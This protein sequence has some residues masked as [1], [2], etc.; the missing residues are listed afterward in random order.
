MAEKFLYYLGAG[1]SANALPIVNDIKDEGGNT[2]RH[3]LLTTMLQTAN[4]LQVFK[5]NNNEQ[6]EFLKQLCSDIKR[7][8][9]NAKDFHSIDTYAKYLHLVDKSELSFLKKTLSAFFTIYQHWGNKVDKRY[10]S[11][12]ASVMDIKMFPENIKIISWNYDYQMQLAA[13]KFQEESASKSSNLTVHKPPLISYFPSIGWS[14]P[15]R[16]DPNLS[17]VH[18]NGLASWFY[19]K[20]TELYDNYHLYPDTLN[21]NSNLFHLRTYNDGQSMNFAWEKS[22]NSYMFNAAEKIVSDTTIIVIIGYSFPFFNRNIDNKIFKQI[23]ESN[24]LK[25]IY[26]QDPVLNGQFLRAQ[27]DLDYSIEIEHIANVES[28]FIPFEL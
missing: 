11:W 1:A 5:S 16:E 23:K 21:K 26:F 24:K 27:F 10:L 13:S 22:Y 7:V 19:N 18:L 9:E 6:R 4:E 2:I 12:I 20:E 3:G 17:M 25:K 8:C 28:F 15:P 14:G